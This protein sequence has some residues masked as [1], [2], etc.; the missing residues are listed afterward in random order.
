MRFRR[1]TRTFLSVLPF[2]PHINDEW[3]ELF[4]PKT[5]TSKNAFE[6][7]DLKTETCKNAS[8]SCGQTKTETFENGVG[9]SSLT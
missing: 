5:E 7:G 6:S 4:P 1:K 8:F 2:R 9:P 3:V